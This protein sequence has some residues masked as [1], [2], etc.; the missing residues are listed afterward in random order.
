MYMHMHLH[1]F[2]HKKKKDKISRYVRLSNSNIYGAGGPN[3]SFKMLAPDKPV[4]ERLGLI[5]FQNIN[6]SNKKW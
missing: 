6:K 4:Q 3:Q 2:E 1:L 5:H